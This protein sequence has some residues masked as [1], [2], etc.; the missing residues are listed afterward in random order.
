MILLTLHPVFG[1]IVF[2]VHFLHFYLYYYSEPKLRN[3][4]FLQNIFNLHIRQAHQSF[5]LITH[6]SIL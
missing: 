5:L 3:L 4:Y 6:N 1:D 2:T